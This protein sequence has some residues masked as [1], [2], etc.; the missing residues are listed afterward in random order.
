M[1]E[2]RGHKDMFFFFFDLDPIIT[3]PVSKDAD[4]GNNILWMAGGY[5]NMGAMVSLHAWAL[6]SLDYSQWRQ[7]GYIKEHIPHSV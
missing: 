7:N 3:Q 4:L 1:L 2:P 6:Y 5:L